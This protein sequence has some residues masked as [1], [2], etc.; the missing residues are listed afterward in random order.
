MGNVC[1]I[2]VSFHI[3]A[4]K[5]CSIAWRNSNLCIISNTPNKSTYV[6][7]AEH[8]NELH[9]IEKGGERERRP[10]GFANGFISLNWCKIVYNNCS[11]LMFAIHYLLLLH[12]N[13][14]YWLTLFLTMQL[15]RYVS[16][17]MSSVFYLLQ[18]IRQKKIRDIFN[19]KFLYSL[20]LYGRTICIWNWV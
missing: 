10:R 18:K 15:L 12:F 16:S 5:F 2:W 9:W 7:N 20:N 13:V 19:S 11:F 4:S 17:G 1:H 14:F 8:I 6:Y 3:F